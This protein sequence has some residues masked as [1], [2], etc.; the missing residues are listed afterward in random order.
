[1]SATFRIA[2]ASLCLTTFASHSALGGEVKRVGMVFPASSSSTAFAERVLFERLTTL[3]W[4]EGRNLAVTKRYA[5]GKSAAA[6][7]LLGEVSSEH[8]DLIVTAG[9]QFVIA[10]KKGSSTIPIVGVMGDPVGAKLVK[11]LGHPGG[12]VTGVSVQNAEEIPRKWLELIRE[13]VPHVNS[14]A[15]II[16]PDNPLHQSVIT[17]MSRAAGN[18][19]INLSVLAAG[20]IEDYPLVFKAARARAQGVVVASDAVAIHAREL[21]AQLALQ[22]RLPALGAQ[23]EFVEAGGFMA[24]GPDEKVTWSR[25]AEYVDKILRGANPGDLPVQQPTEFRLWVNLRTAKALGI[26]IPESILLR[27][28]EVIR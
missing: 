4:V 18:A 1:M 21:I 25:V 17:R 6:P 23:G 16:N 12:N 9:T 15:L 28:D 27:A 11:S 2:L 10:A 7:S 13:A 8:V 24:Y 3:G 20:G 22:Y 14:V 5:D 19:Q 26:T